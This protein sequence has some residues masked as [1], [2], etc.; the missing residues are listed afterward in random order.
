[1]SPALACLAANV[2]PRPAY[3]PGDLKCD[4]G[5]LFRVVRVVWDLTAW[6]YIVRP[7]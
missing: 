5:F 7:A 4:D 3:L 2:K 1:M 6:L